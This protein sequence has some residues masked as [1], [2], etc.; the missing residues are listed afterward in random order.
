MIYIP[1]ERLTAQF[2]VHL[3][4]DGLNHGIVSVTGDNI[5]AALSI[6][7]ADDCEEPRLNAS[8]PTQDSGAASEPE[9]REIACSVRAGPPYAGHNDTSSVS[10]SERKEFGVT[11]LL[12]ALEAQGARASVLNF[13]K[14]AN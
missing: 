10:P 5:N 6:I 2:P 7:K 3:L 8:S 9:S 12:L 1:R 14:N 11:N 13:A 4:G